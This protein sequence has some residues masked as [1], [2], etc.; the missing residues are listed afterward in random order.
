MT[1]AATA[2]DGSFRLP[3]YKAITL[4]NGLTL[5][6]ME[7]H[8]V[9]LINVNIVVKGG[10]LADGPQSGLARVTAQALM[11][12][13]QTMGRVELENQF[14]FVGARVGSSAEKE[15]NRLT[16]SFAA[17][18]T[19]LML[20]LLR[21]VLLVP[22]F[23]DEEFAKLQRR[24]LSGLTQQ[25]E[26][27]RAVI[28]S[29]FDALMF[30]GHPYAAAAEGDAQAVGAFNTD[31]L[32][33]FHGRVY[34]PQNTAVCVAGDFKTKDL[35]KALRTLFGDWARGE[36]QAA[37]PSAPVAPTRSRVLLVDK[38]DARETT[39]YIG[40]PG[41]ARDNPDYVGIQVINTILGGRFTSW[42]ND[43]LRVNAGLTYGARSR[44]R[45]YGQG[46][47]F[48]ISTFTRTP[49]TIQAVELALETY[50]RLWEQGVDQKTLDSAKAYVKG[51]FP[52]D[53]ETAGQLARLLANMYVYGL[54]KGFIDDF[55]QKVDALTLEKAQRIIAQR[56]PRE[57]L[58]F[59]MIG[60]AADIESDVTR[61][62]E[63]SKVEIQANGFDF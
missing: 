9:P 28:A 37:T 61:Y 31:D 34:Q 53:Y 19:E 26:S 49:T 60:N 48:A 56:F 32:R 17:K 35:E 25:K 63:I 5:L 29:Y 52:P 11:T 15:L 2:G 27:P 39:F 4:D 3:E 40:G 24:Y 14:D 38:A 41:V 12:G 6:L 59:V 23:D 50:G 18:D 36:T 30:Q 44:F 45:M 21:D 33:G 43:E 62:G 8:E 51:Q 42:L 46:G 55:E 16:A 57:K 47:S 58:Q 22:A 20:P 10:A 54:D 7:Q 1:S 13:T